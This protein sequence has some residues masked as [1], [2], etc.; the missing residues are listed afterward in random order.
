MTIGFGEGWQAKQQQEE[1]VARSVESEAQEEVSIGVLS[2]KNFRDSINHQN[3]LSDW[4]G[5]LLTQQ[6]GLKVRNSSFVRPK[7]NVIDSMRAMTPMPPRADFELFARGDRSFRLR[8]VFYYDASP[9][10]EYDSK[11]VFDANNAL[12]IGD[13]EP[14]SDSHTSAD[15]AVQ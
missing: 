4:L 12:I 7:N 15:E 10:A 14:V 8:T 3:A 5:G 11:M 13:L 1:V 2:K 6:S 9:V